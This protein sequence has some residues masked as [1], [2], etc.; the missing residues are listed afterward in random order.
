MTTCD[1]N[2]LAF[3]KICLDNCKSGKGKIFI[4]NIRIKK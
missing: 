1:A 4:D 2:T 3:A